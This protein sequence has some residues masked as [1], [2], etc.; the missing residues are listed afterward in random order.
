MD[1]ASWL[2]GTCSFEC[3]I[4]GE[5]F[6]HSIAFYCHLAADHKTRP[7]DYAAKHGSALADRRTVECAHC[8]ETI[9]HEKGSLKK[10]F[11]QKHPGVRMRDYFEQFVK[12]GEEASRS[13]VDPVSGGP[14]VEGA[15]FCQD[16]EDNQRPT[17]RKG[18]RSFSSKGEHNKENLLE[19]RQ[20]TTRG[21]KPGEEQGENQMDEKEM[22]VKCGVCGE[23]LRD[24]KSLLEHLKTKHR[25][26]KVA[27]EVQKVGK[28]DKTFKCD[29]CG[30]I[31]SG[32]EAAS[33][34]IVK[35]NH[36]TFST[37]INDVANI[38]SEDKSKGDVAPKDDVPTAHM[39]DCGEKSKD[40][41]VTINPGGD[42]KA[43]KHDI[44]IDYFTI[45]DE[46]TLEEDS[47][48]PHPQVSDQCEEEPADPLVIEAP[49]PRPVVQVAK[50]PLSAACPELLADERNF[51]A[52]LVSTH[53]IS[54]SQTLDILVAK[55][56]THYVEI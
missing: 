23:A 13:A 40:D 47:A 37:V 29:S 17:R 31:L 10:H 52:H 6:P 42:A 32:F 46:V 35:H 41:V 3:A 50:C 1:F 30:K 36:K 25:K 34:H 44:H 48:E 2:S 49:A 55:I 5:R 45:G 38:K 33:S 22:A 54:D 4:C 51:T 20:I 15:A 11:A 9:D 43:P 21:T 39:E 19:K 16:R 27:R 24:A 14:R 28:G 26:V 56:K 8:L 7:A 18:R 53:Q 12:P